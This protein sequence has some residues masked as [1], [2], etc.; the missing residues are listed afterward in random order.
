MEGPGP[1]SP[2]PI[3]GSSLLPWC[4]VQGAY[5]AG[6]KVLELP[7]VVNLATGLDHEGHHLVDMSRLLPFFLQLCPVM[8]RLKNASFLLS[9]PA[10][11]V[12]PILAPLPALSLYHS[13]AGS[14]SL[15]H[16]AAV[17]N[18]ATP[19]ECELPRGRSSSERLAYPGPTS[20]F[21]FFS[22]NSAAVLLSLARCPTPSQCH[23]PRGCGQS[24]VNTQ[25]SCLFSLCNCAAP[26]F[27]FRAKY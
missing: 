23:V 5:G 14:L 12:S 7:E 17:P 26:L 18:H 11:R 22:F 21:L 27:L 9:D 4:F 19:H 24:V 16:N 8:P 1:S 10:V 15:C 20:L 2:H 3:G 13:A 6:K 25:Y